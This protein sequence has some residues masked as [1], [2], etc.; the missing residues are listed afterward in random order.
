MFSVIAYDYT[1][2]TTITCRNVQTKL[3]IDS[4]TV[5]FKMNVSFF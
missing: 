4:M 2:T 3:I 5:D 1:A